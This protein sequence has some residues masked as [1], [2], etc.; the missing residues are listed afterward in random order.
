[1][2]APV[3]VNIGWARAASTAFRQNFL[4]QHPDLFTLDRSGSLL[5]VDASLILQT[6]KGAD[7]AT[8]Q[9]ELPG[10]RRRWENLVRDRGHRVLCLSDEELSIGHMRT[11]ILPVTI[12][13][14]CAT[15]FPGARTLAVVRD[16]VD[17]L[18]SFYHL[19]A[20]ATRGALPLFPDWVDQYFLHPALGDDFRYLFSYMP[21]LLAYRAQ[22]GSDICV[23]AYDRLKTSHADVY[24]DVARWL[25]VSESACNPLPN[26]VVNASPSVAADYAPGQSLAVNALFAADNAQ[27]AREF[28]VSFSPSS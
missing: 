6:L 24:R 15:L 17:T 20:R 1:M 10:L 14:R 12:A 7:D 3:V 8:F 11:G 26:N 23:V 25:G 28:G 5:G 27:L 13:R 22:P 19:A 18:R 4:R 21:T 2:T 16:Q 9:A